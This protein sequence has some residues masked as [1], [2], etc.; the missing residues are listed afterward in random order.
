MSVHGG[1]CQ[2]L[3]LSALRYIGDHADGV[4]PSRP[5]RRRRLLYPLGVI[6]RQHH[7]HPGPHESPCHTQPNAAGGACDD[8]H[9]VLWFEAHHPVLA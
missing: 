1:L 6:V 9:L 7:F 3:H 5:Q 2:C 4:V 8:S